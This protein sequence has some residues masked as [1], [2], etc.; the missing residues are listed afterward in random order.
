MI[1][2]EITPRKGGGNPKMARSVAVRI[3][4]QGF[5]RISIRAGLL[6]QIGWESLERVRVMFGTEADAGRLRLEPTTVGGYKICRSGGS[7]NPAKRLRSR[8]VTL[9]CDELQRRPT[10]LMQ[11]PH[12][13]V[14]LGRTF[15]HACAVALEIDLPQA[16]LLAKPLP[17]TEAA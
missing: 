4:G 9:K 15:E 2:R 6:R 13:C 1:W 8:I 5:L 7:L 17:Q 11:V 12:R 10:M 14:E 16:W 3:E